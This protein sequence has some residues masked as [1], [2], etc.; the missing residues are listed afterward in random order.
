MANP[1]RIL[2]VIV[3]PKKAKTGAKQATDAI[4]RFSTFGASEMKKFANHTASAGKQLGRHIS[5]GSKLANQAL[6]TIAPAALVAGQAIMKIGQISATV[7]NGVVKNVSGAIRAITRFTSGV[8]N[9]FGTI[10]RVALPLGVAGIFDKIIESGLKMTKFESTMSVVTGSVQASRT[11]LEGLLETSNQL[12]IVFSNAAAPFAKFAAAARGI[13]P[14]QDIKKI[15]D[16]FAE[17]SSALFLTN[18][19]INGVFLALQ[20]MASKGTISMEELRLQLAERIPGA[21]RLAARAMEM[22]VGSLEEAIRAGSVRAE[23][24]LVKFA[25]VIHENFAGAARIAA[26]SAF[27]A[28]NNLK[29]QLFQTAVDISNAG[30]L[31]ALADGATRLTKFLKDNE[32]ELSTLGRDIANLIS[33]IV[34]QMTR[35]SADDA[36]SFF[37]GISEFLGVLR[38]AVSDVLSLLNSVQSTMES[39]GNSTLVQHLTSATSAWLTAVKYVGGLGPRAYEAAFGPDPEAPIQGPQAPPGFISR[40]R[41]DGSESREAAEQRLGNDFDQFQGQTSAEFLAEQ[42]GIIARAQEQLAKSEL[43]ILRDRRREV[44]AQIQIQDERLE[45]LSQTSDTFI[46]AEGATSKYVSALK[47]LKELDEDIVKI[48]E[49]LREN[50]PAFK[51]FQELQRLIASVQGS[52]R[53]PAET[54]QKQIDDLGEAFSVGA[55]NDRGGEKEYRRL[56][57]EL[58]EDLDELEDKANKAQKTITEFALSAARNMQSA[59]ADFLFDPFE[60]GLKGMLKGFS[61]TL[62]RMAAEIASQYLLQQFFGALAGSNNSILSSIGNAF[63]GQTAGSTP[64]GGGRASGGAVFARRSYL[65]GEN[66]PEVVTMAGNGYVSPSAGSSSGNVEVKVINNTGVEADADARV[67]QV[68]G[69]TVVDVVLSSVATDIARRGVVSKAINSKNNLARR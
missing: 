3:D 37:S 61:D 10:S 68:G 15:F 44:K 42:R 45:S 9:S 20:Q 6:R 46:E 51:R 64:N 59:F 16:A 1:R 21:M 17:V 52:T 47:T 18:Q 43:Q 25:D 26:T 48:E 30:V 36:R 23:D 69:K 66:G 4:K 5:T 34:D 8:V 11:Q 57:S 29:N 38:E 33:D 54:I 22:D 7:F 50:S 40:R 60:N 58:L 28:F 35:I 12:G 62:R 55:F 24:F 31:D 39:L 49:K 27:A 13:I 53:T 32:K 14:E 41:L 67:T 65:V 19:E 63:Q 56:V 2:E